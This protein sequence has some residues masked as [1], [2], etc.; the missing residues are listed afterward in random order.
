MLMA[1]TREISPAIQQCELTHLQRTPIDLDRARAQHAD[2]EWALV[3]AGLTVRRLH[4]ADDMP[5]S[6]FVEDIAVIL[7]ELAVLTRPGADPRR[8]ETPAIM[9][10]LIK[11]QA[12]RFR[13]LVMI[14]EPGT[15]DGGDVLV[16]GQQIFVGASSRTNAAGIDQLRRHASRAGYRVQ[17]VPVRGCLHLKSAVTAVGPETVLINPAWVPPDA[18]ADYTRIEVDPQERHAANALVLEDRV[19]YP[20]AF[21]RTRERL[22]TAGVTIRAVDVSELAKAE[23]AV[24]CC[25]LIFEV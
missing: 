10:A 4:T 9:D 17:A 8:A 3:E 5:D 24:T 22:E 16:I 2:Y 15:L 11:V 25:S 7:D 6:V 20:T 12:L 23:G 14:E 13:P 18:F 19:I 21:P 1:L